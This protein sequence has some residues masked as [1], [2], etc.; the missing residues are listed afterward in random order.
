ME[1]FKRGINKIIGQKLM[2]SGYPSISI[3]QWYKLA[4]NLDRYWRE[5]RQE[6]E[7]LRNRR[8]IRSLAL[9]INTSTNIRGAK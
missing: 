1:E 2:E 3:E 9:R 5:N 7:R 6:E 8:K 4:T